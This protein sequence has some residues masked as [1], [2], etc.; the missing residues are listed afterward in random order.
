MLY[1]DSFQG[2]ANGE[3]ITTGCNGRGS[4]SG[5]GGGGGG[6]EVDCQGVVTCLHTNV[7]VC[8]MFI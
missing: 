7:L 3:L 2:V 6:V 1:I 5:G 4:P 8:Y